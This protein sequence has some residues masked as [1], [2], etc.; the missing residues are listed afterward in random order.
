MRA[1]IEESKHAVETGHMPFGGVVADADG[2]ILVRGHNLCQAGS[3]RGGSANT[4]PTQHAEMEIVRIACTMIDASIRPSCTLYTSTEPC[5]MCAGAIYWSRIGRIVYGCSSEAL[6]QYTGPGGFDIPIETIYTLGRPGTRHIDIQGPYLSEEA[7]KVHVESGVWG[8]TAGISSSEEDKT[9]DDD[10]KN[11]VDASA[12]KDIAVEAA[13]FTS[14]LGSAAS[15]NDLVVPTIDMSVGTDEEIANALWEAATTVGFFTIVNHGIAS[16]L[17]DTVFETSAQFFAQTQEEKERQSPYARNL[18]SGYEFMKQLRPSTGTI[19]QKESIQITA[20]AG[21]MDDRWPT[22]PTHFRS[23]TETFMIQVHALAGRLLDLLEPRATPN[24]DQGTMSSSHTLWGHDGQCTLRMLHYLPMDVETL[25]TLT[26]PDEQGRISW[27][28]GP[29]TDWSNL[30][31][32]F[33][34]VGQAGLE[35][36]S[37]P[38]DSN[39]ERRWTPID[40]VENGIAVN[41]GD[42]LSRW[43]HHRLYSN[44]HRVRMPTESE[45][46]PPSSRYSIAYFAQSDQSTMIQSTSDVDPPITAG[47]YL[48]SRIK[49]NFA[50]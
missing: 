29:H 12:M 34:R 17:I 27:R 18:N 48:L 9:E 1:A 23:V 46:T 5:V 25:R 40:P 39:K 31:L 49:S 16:E 50:T 33:Q 21:S 28:A 36:C 3:T 6:S 45:C 19:D 20:R 41:I 26:T 7:M 42:M 35:C 2:N 43:S 14:G 32:L 22:T 38:T 11:D 44:L 10:V 4:D 15:S 13:L 24:V 37:N 47:D 30:T 8:T